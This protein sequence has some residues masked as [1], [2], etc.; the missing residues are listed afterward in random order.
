[1][2]ALRKA[3]TF[4]RLGPRRQALALEASA[5]LAIARL[6]LAIHPFS[7]VAQRLGP[8]SSSRSDPTAGPSAPSP[9]DARVAREI[10][11]AVRAVAPW[12][13]FRAVCLQQAMAARAML[14]RRGIGSTL[15]L[16]AGPDGRQELSA[17]AWLD[18][19]GAPVTGFPVEPH[20]AEIGRFG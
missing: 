15:H 5:S 4:V 19:A 14:R 1:M 12:M 16:G 8:F 3:W 2:Q 13:P 18:C 17:H 9:N 7:R 20:I 10:G 11:W 6:T